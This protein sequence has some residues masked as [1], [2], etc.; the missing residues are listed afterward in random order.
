MT[1][2]VDP[3]SPSV[4]DPAS[5]SSAD[6]TFVGP[7]GLGPGSEQ[8]ATSAQATSEASIMRIPVM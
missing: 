1:V 4:V 3:P 5:D 6:S 7:A 8:P 2:P